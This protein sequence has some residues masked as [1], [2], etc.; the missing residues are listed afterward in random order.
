MSIPPLEFKANPM[1]MKRTILL[2]SI[3]FVVLMGAVLTVSILANHST[4]RVELQAMKKIEF[5]AVNPVSAPQLSRESEI[6]TPTQENID[7]QSVN[8]VSVP[9][10]N[11]EPE[12]IPLDEVW[13]MLGQVNYDRALDDLSQ[14]TGEEPICLSY[15]CYTITHR[16]TGSQGLDWAQGYL[17]ENLVD[18]GY[19]VEIND[20]SS[21][22]LSDQNLIA[23]KEGVLNPSEEVYFV[24]HVDGVRTYN[25]NFPAADDNASSVVNGLELARILSVYE[26]ERTLVLFF[27][28]GEE[29][30]R[31]GVKEYLD[32]LSSEE[33]N[34]IEYVVNR[35]MTGYDGN[36][37]RVMELFHGDHPASIALTQMMGDI[38]EAYQLDLVPMAVAGCP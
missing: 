4:T 28:S 26:F 36:G 2:Y 37:N 25:N 11:R 13:D 32:Q 12:I 19:D 22:G 8:S 24:A 17:Y 23:R 10:S 31:L 29:Q 7:S 38:I 18:L 9:Q 6:T 20:W 34:A 16:L 1:N 21:S 15:G 35:D 30:G 33:L 5:P 27:S 3:A 14:L